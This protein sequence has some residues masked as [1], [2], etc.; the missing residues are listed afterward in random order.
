[1]S[2]RF[3]EQGPLFPAALI[4]AVL[5]GDAVFLC[6]TG[7][8]APQLPTFKQLVDSVSEALGVPINASEQL[9]YDS[10][11]FEEVLGSLSRRLAEPSHMVR[12]A[13]AALSVPAD[14]RL[15][16]HKTVLRLSRDLANRVLIVTTN[17]DTLLERGM[18]ALEPAADIV[19]ESFAGQALPAPGSATFSGIIHLHGRL[20]DAP[21]ALDATPLVLTSADYGDAYM[22]SGWASR[23]LF[24]LARCK[25]IVL[26]GYSAGDAPVRYFLNVLEADR[27]RFPDL[28]S[29]YAF[30]SYEH[31][32]VEAEKPWGTVAVT[33][34]A[35]SKVN[36]DTHAHDHSP[37]WRD[38]ALL[39]DLVERP[40]ANRDARLRAILSQPSSNLTDPMLAELRWLV[41]G[42]AD[43]W[44][45]AVDTIEDPRWFTIFQEND[46][47]AA[48]HAQW[49]VPA[50]IARNFTDRARFLTAVEWQERLGRPFTERLSNRLQAGGALAPGWRKAWR[51]LTYAAPARPDAFEGHVYSLKAKL[52]SGLVLEEDVRR[53]VS[54]LT[55]VLSLRRPFRGF[56]DD[57]GD[58]DVDAAA[59][60]RRLGDL[61]R[62]EFGRDDRDGV[63]ELVETLAALD[64]EARRILRTASTALLAAVEQAVDLDLVHGDID[65]SDF[66]VPSVEEHPQN[67]FH[68]GVLPLVRVIVAAFT[69]VAA[70]DRE[71]ARHI[72]AL[73]SAIPGRIG[74]R[75]MLHAMR[76]KGAFEADEAMGFLN[77][78]EETRF[79]N[80]RREIAML[81]VD[82][83]AEAEPALVGAIEQRILET[84]DAFFSR[85]T[86]AEGQ[87]DWRA[88]ARD[89]EVWLRLSQLDAAG[90]LSEAG[91]TEL[92]A[93][94]VRRPHLD[95]GLEDRDFFSSYTGGVRQV[96]GDIAPITSAAPD[97]RLSVV[98][99]LAMSPDIEKQH[100]WS[101]YCRTD[102]KGAFDT[103][104][105]A[106]LTPV[107]LALWDTLIS[108]LSFGDESTKALREDIAV[109]ILETLTGLTDEALKS[110]AN[111]LVDL[112]L[113]GPR[114]RLTGRED[115]YD[116][117]WACLRLDEREVAADTDLADAALNNAAGRFAR[118]L[119]QEHEASRAAEDDNRE[120]QRARLAVVGADAGRAGTYV[121]A[122]FVQHIA[123]LLT[124]DEAL[125]TNILTPRLD[126][127]GEG[128]ALR[129][130]LIRYGAITPELTRAIPEVILKG[131]REARPGIGGAQPVAAAILRPALAELCG[132][133]DPQW[134]ITAAQV[135]EVLR[136][137]AGEIRKAALDVLVRWMHNDEASVE[138]AWAIMV[139]P[140]LEQ[141][142]PKERRFVDE[143]NNIH[144]AEL[145]VGAGAQFPAAL[146]VVRPYIAPYSGRPG[147]VHSI[148]SSTAPANFPRQTLELLWMLFGSTGPTS[149]DTAALL[150]SLVAA[151]ADIEVDRR[152]QSLGQRSERY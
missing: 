17:F 121:R 8:S 55:P 34:I 108:S 99:E 128:P 92:A 71:A 134:G 26:L 101:T 36:P 146:A 43:P 141:L 75:L 142:W 97:D 18:A 32:P 69:K 2:L 135:C 139:Q 85:Y 76:D 1:M 132:D 104:A 123:F 109:E 77:G 105:A 22:R 67:E 80:I 25:T 11:R 84:G 29:V 145:A 33:P 149:Y 27:T 14:P 137:V 54:M 38:L 37:L 133:M 117:L 72:A 23:F 68:G 62:V 125:V 102:P 126:G 13:A 151:D 64:G 59:D 52:E 65:D 103:L 130:V 19:G 31:D 124:A 44:P 91:K 57:E 60:P 66:A 9:A 120:R 40:K 100:G 39:A 74:T 115:W 42:G 51:Q 16:Q 136:E 4:D 122:T 98:Q 90:V 88:H 131:V 20:E 116:R 24:D 56:E 111:A 129:A 110:V 49:V 53:A 78:L 73:W 21:F 15:D 119:L 89:N 93:I 152:L 47:W 81:L 70:E 10:N 12:A 45:T 6:G 63:N 150:D 138:Q 87:P 118:V 83:A 95:R 7:I 127:D 50:W 58:G 35:Y 86:I 114:L 96:V 30:D 79:W 82:R 143:A 5:S 3:S 41:S 147:S 61:A 107:N 140:F 113:F 148:K 46:L 48:Q 28:R 112:F 94:K 144:L 106:P